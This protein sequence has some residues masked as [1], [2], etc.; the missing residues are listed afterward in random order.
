MPVVVAPP[1]A[2][3]FC[4]FPPRRH[5]RALVRCQQLPRRRRQARGQRP[6]RRRRARAAPIALRR[7]HRSGSDRS[8]TRLYDLAPTPAPTKKKEEADAAVTRQTGSPGTLRTWMS[9]LSLEVGAG[10][11]KAPIATA[12]VGEACKHARALYLLALCIKDLFILILVSYPCF[13]YGD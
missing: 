1:Y 10:P 6:R 2:A 4:S 8:D 11:A 13:F 7:R 3:P 9:S 12:H 5:R